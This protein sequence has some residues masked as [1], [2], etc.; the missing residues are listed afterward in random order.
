MYSG[1]LNFNNLKPF[2]ISN[3]YPPQEDHRI[4]YVRCRFA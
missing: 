3:F 2:G 4:Y 1:I